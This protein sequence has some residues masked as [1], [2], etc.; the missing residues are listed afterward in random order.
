MY[1]KSSFPASFIL[2]DL[3]ESCQSPGVDAVVPLKHRASDQVRA[4][5]EPGVPVRALER[6]EAVGFGVTRGWVGRAH[7][8][9]KQG[10]SLGKRKPWVCAIPYVWRLASV[11]MI[12]R[13][14]NDWKHGAVRP[15][16][17]ALPAIG[18][19]SC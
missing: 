17:C 4:G 1:S 2:G 8:L 7:T 6:G 14:R 12:P 13:R 19:S 11:R 15:R 10:E 3:A 9:E 16:A 5:I 18:H